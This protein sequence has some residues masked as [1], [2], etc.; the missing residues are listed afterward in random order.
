M[1]AARDE[2]NM[3]ETPIGARK[4]ILSV[5]PP[6][7]DKDTKNCPS[8]KQGEKVSPKLVQD[9]KKRVVEIDLLSTLNANED[10]RN[11]HGGSGQQGHQN[12]MADQ[13][14]NKADMT[15][16][17]AVA[18]ILSGATE[19][20][21]A[22]KP[23]TDDQDNANKP[24]EPIVKP[25]Q[26]IT[27]SAVRRGRP[28]RLRALSV[29]PPAN[30]EDTEE[31]LMSMLKDIQTNMS[32]S[33][34]QNVRFEHNVISSLDT[35]LGELK[36]QYDA[37]VGKLQ[38]DMDGHGA[39]ICHMQSKL[40][41]LDIKFIDT[42][43]R[44]CDL[45][46][47]ISACRKLTEDS[48]E[49]VNVHMGNVE[50][51]LAKD[52]E[53]IRRSAEVKLNENQDI[54][55]E[56]E[57]RVQDMAAHME[58]ENKRLENELSDMKMKFDDLQNLVEETESS[59]NSDF[60]NKCDRCSNYDENAASGGS[61]FS[62]EGAVG[63]E[64]EPK[65]LNAFRSLIIDGVLEH[66]NENLAVLCPRFIREI[67]IKI[68]PDDIEVAFR[69]G[70]RDPKRPRPRAV[71][72]VLNSELIRDQVYHFKKRLRLSRIF[73]SFQISYD[74]E[75]NMRVKHGILKR[76]A[77]IA[78]S[79]GKEVYSTPYRIKI[80]GVEYDITHL[81]EIPDQYRDANSDETVPKEPPLNI[82]RLTV[83]ERA[84]NTSDRAIKIGTGL[85]KTQWGLLFFSAVLSQYFF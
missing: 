4:R 68:D 46:D 62:D 5:T 19:T 26:R 66:Q 67:G 37:S 22:K 75:K 51:S 56:L 73:S 63:P 6:N 70:R 39:S 59:V 31:G 2:T 7:A 83:F 24:T 15:G 53:E 17:P 8:T 35:K 33:S 11:D 23:T 30:R 55:R 10:T 9:L 74:L 40:Q 25:D 76:A 57:N 18:P 80:E 43:T 42:E 34:L 82:R 45:E 32:N 28:R 69:L 38:T 65:Q 14:N 21:P 64:N 48:I 29:D 36:H 3:A 72:L 47:D 20:K 27:R 44:M 78:R 77:T 52:I 58:N 13:S 41:G 16:K 81:D 61:V 50:T 60:T 49:T 71:K 54:Q 85:Q 1:E 12:K 79:Q 84:R